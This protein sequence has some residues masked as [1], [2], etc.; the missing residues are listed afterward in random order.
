MPINETSGTELQPLDF[1]LSPKKGKFGKTL[2]MA[3]IPEDLQNKAKYR[4]LLT[5]QYAEIA[6]FVIDYI[7][8]K[9]AV[10]IFFWSICLI[11]L[12]I[13][14]MVRIDISGLYDFKKILIHTLLGLIVFP[15]AIIP[16][17]EGLH[18][19]PYFISGARN[20]RFGMDL[21]QYMFYVTAH[22]YVASPLQFRVVALIP[23]VFISLSVFFLTLYL[24]GLW[25][26][27]LSLF[28]FVHTTMC[29]GD[30]AMINFYFVNRSGKIYTWDDADLKEAYFYQEI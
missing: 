22:K 14:V 23:F 26:W 21:N 4:H 12:G 28:L 5:L 8:R 1:V 7:R 25:K 27:S 20:I 24:P 19:I 13:S 16:V 3:K 9:T 29:A 18:I 17:H 15:L 2:G 6:S 11:F 10:T 30:F